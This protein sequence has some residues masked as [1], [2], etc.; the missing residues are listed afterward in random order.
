MCL[1][2]IACSRKQV[3]EAREVLSILCPYCSGHKLTS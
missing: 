1:E 2:Q 3:I